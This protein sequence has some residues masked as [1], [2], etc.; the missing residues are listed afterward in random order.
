MPSQAAPSNVTAALA[1]ICVSE[2]HKSH[3]SVTLPLSAHLSHPS[4]RQMLTVTKQKRSVPGSISHS[5]H[6]PLALVPKQPDIRRPTRSLPLVSERVH[7]YQG[8]L[9]KSAGVYNC[10]HTQETCPGFH[11]SLYK[12]SNQSVD[13]RNA[14]LRTVVLA[15]GSA[16][17]VGASGGN[18]AAAPEPY[19]QEE[20]AAERAVPEH[21]RREFSEA[22]RPKA[23][24]VAPASGHLPLR[25]QGRRSGRTCSSRSHSSVHPY[26]QAVNRIKEINKSIKVQSD[27][28]AALMQPS[29]ASKSQ[30][31]L[32]ALPSLAPRSGL[33]ANDSPRVASERQGPFSNPGSASWPSREWDSDSSDSLQTGRRVD[34]VRQHTKRTTF[35]HDVVM[36]DSSNGGDRP[37]IRK[38]G[39]ERTPLCWL[40]NL[41][42]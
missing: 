12:A 5:L 14:A 7:R 41:V 30:G 24:E 42:L 1:Q 22:Q 20:I 15:T 16:P 37:S 11:Q 19:S 31:G 6:H 4:M 35:R 33:A 28:L 38:L 39:V 2:L 18:Q 21:V 3:Q 13:H 32:G 34:S 8:L 40:L 10:M 23:P 17:E 26:A 36:K 27:E 29:V 9:F 25:K